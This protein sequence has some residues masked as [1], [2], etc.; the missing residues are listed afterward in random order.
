MRVGG[1][2]AESCLTGGIHQ[3]A[4]GGTQFF[5][6]VYLDSNLYVQVF[7]RVMVYCN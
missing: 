7:H 3:L 2:A 1:I 4:V 5:V 6:V